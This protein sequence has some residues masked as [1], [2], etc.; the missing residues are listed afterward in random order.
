[1]DTVQR[2]YCKVCGWNGYTNIRIEACQNPKCN[3]SIENLEVEGA[4]WGYGK[5][6]KC[7]DDLKQRFEAKPPANMYDRVLDSIVQHKEFRGCWIDQKPTRNGGRRIFIGLT[8]VDDPAACDLILK[9]WGIKDRV[10]VDPTDPKNNTLSVIL[11]GSFIQENIDWPE[12][13][14]DKTTA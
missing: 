8:L 9:R 6:I 14:Q 7:F 12:P 3:A 10:W 11:F 4:W 1:M 13:R 2:F 5:T